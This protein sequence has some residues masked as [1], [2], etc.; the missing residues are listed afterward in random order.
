MRPAAAQDSADLSEVDLALVEALQLQP[1]APWTRIGA[2]VG[3]DATTT[4]RRWHRLA[5]RGLAW[6]TAYP[7]GP[8]ATIGYL[9]VSVRP[10][11]LDD[12]TERLCR[13]P[14][15][16]SV[17]QTTGGHQLFLGV[18]ARDLAALGSFATRRLGT[19]TGVRAVRLSVGTR[20]YREGSGW[21]VRALDAEQRSR[22]GACPSAVKRHRHRTNHE[23][24]R[25]LTLALGAD[26][27]RSCADLARDQCLSETAVRRRLTR[28][29]A[30]G[31]LY[32]R[33]DIAQR[34]AG[35]HVTGTY[36]IRVPADHLDT[37]ARDLA[38]LPETR[39]CAAVTG[40]CNLLLQ[41]WARSLDDFQ[42]LEGWLARRHPAG[43]V[44]ERQVSVHT[45][46]RMGRLLDSEG[47]AIGQVPMTAWC[48]PHDAQ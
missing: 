19:L 34:H 44:L 29:L 36:R 40:D 35:W 25:M 28:M 14:Y 37:V 21:L 42:A 10:D 48:G 3:L 27:R 9:D 6:L 31:E 26:A 4:A 39:L 33:C 32:F 13:W 45:A 15:V 46:K 17:E 8:A 12:L 5:G 16:F 1:R 2:A 20:I 43:S 11:A 24:D 38:A 41:V 22:L 23:T 7:A 47:L 18:A 30:N